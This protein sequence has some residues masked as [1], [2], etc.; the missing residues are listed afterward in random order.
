M[1]CSMPGFPAHHQLLEPTQTH[2]YHVGDAT[3]PS[4][5]L[6]SPSPSTLQSFPASGSFPTI[7][8]FTPGDQN[9][10]VSASASILPINIQDWFPLGLTG[11][12]SLK[13]KGLSRVFSNTTV[14]MHQFFINKIKWGFIK[15][16]YTLEGR[17][18]RLRWVATP[19]FFG[20]LVIWAVKVDRMFIEEGCLGVEFPDFLS[21]LY[22]H[23]GKW[24][25]CLSL[26]LIRSVNSSVHD[27]YFL[28]GGLIL[29]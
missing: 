13:S 11:W 8:F 4:H 24:D 23:K 28:Y 9:I 25:F 7:Q 22:L 6:L 10:G 15:Q 12:I 2:V 1:D 27:R 18:G 20:K 21:Q 16:Y 5:P 26:V 14:Q 17:A 19:S 3:Q 29:L